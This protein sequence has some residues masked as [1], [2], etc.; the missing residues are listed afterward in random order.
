MLQ[1]TQVPRV[2]ARWPAFVERFPTATACAAAP[3]GDV[4][5]A[6]AGLGYNRRAVNLHRCASLV[7]DRHDGELPD[8]LGA[9]V[10][11]AGIGPYTARAILVFAHG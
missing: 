6:W 5:R 10:A 11:L 8:E 4:V 2:V 1:Q 9:L 7:V 3:A